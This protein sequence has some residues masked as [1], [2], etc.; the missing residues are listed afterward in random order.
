VPKNEPQP[1]G[2][3]SRRVVGGRADGA[4]LPAAL[5]RRGCARGVESD[6]VKVVEL[7]VVAVVA[8]GGLATYAGG[9]GRA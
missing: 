1:P 2:H 4:G 6:K 3:A 7:M 9:L 8:R 5:A